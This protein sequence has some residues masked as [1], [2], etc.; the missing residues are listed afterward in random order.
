MRSMWRE[1]SGVLVCGL[2]A[3]ALL[4][5]QANAA[6][7]KVFKDCPDCPEMV[8]IPAG[9][10]TWQKQQQFECVSQCS[11]QALTAKRDGRESDRVSQCDVD[12]SHMNS[13]T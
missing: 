2:L 12:F 6:E 8:V 7:V 3:G 4:W 11:R 13:T 10:S 1:I 5:G 9:S